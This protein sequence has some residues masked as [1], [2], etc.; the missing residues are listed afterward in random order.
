M[1]NN[2]QLREE[3]NKIFMCCGKAGCPSVEAVEDD[4]VKISDDFGNSVKMKLA[5][6]ELIK[7]A[8]D[9][10]IKNNEE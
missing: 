7:S 2:Y 8:V 5:E 3:G 1:K 9:K 4:L 10:L 6:A